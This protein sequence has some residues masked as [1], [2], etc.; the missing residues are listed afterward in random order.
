L[1]EV[2]T[3]RIGIAAA[4]KPAS[5]P[6]FW[7]SMSATPPDKPTAPQPPPQPAPEPA[8]FDNPAI[9]NLIA[10]TLE[11]GAELWVQRERMRVIEKLLAD[12]GVVTAE[13]IEQYQP[14]AEE[15]ARSRVDRDAFVSRVYG[16]FARQTVKATP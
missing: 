6:L 4:L 8:F 5:Q 7:R 9:D 15:L 10:V 13:L 14:S 11:L 16:A 1:R 12:K 3:E 2:V